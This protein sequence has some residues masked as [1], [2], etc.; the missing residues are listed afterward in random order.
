MVKTV[1]LHKNGP[2]VSNLIYG[3]WRILD[4]TPQPSPRDILK[5]LEGCLELGI[6]TL[7]TAEIYGGYTVEAALGKAFS[8]SPSLKEQFTIVSKAGIDIPSSEKTHARLNH[9]DASEANLVRCV[10]K[11]LQLMGVE[12]LNLFL[13]HRPDWLTRAEDT[14]AGLNR[15]IQEGKILHAGVSNYSRSEFELL[16]QFV[17][18][19]LVT[20]QL[21]ISLLHMDALYDG[22]LNQAEAMG[23]RPMAWSALAGGK[24]FNQEI[25]ASQRL[26]EAMEEMRNRYDGAPDDVLAFA[27][28]MAHPSQP[29]P[30]LGTNKM[31]RIRSSAQAASIQLERQDWFALWEAAKGYSVP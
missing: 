19:P 29:V 25:A 6:H 22:T 1:S 9:Y 23:A 21:E 16:S 11:S 4:V 18:Q 5:R 10:E 27:W 26:H 12:A 7:D 17:D 14:A 31:E 20:N 28:V 30:I 24:I 13:V 8:L 15:L 2:D 3:T